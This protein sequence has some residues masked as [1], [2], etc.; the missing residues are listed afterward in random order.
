MLVSASGSQ[1]AGKTTVLSKL[2][3]KYKIIER[4]TSRSILSDWGVTLSQVNND[5]SLTVQFQ[6]EI[7]KRKLNDDTRDP[8]R[9]Y[10]TERTFADL[11]VYALVA[12]GKDNEYSDWLDDYY[13]RCMQ[14]QERYDLVFYFTAG[15]FAPPKDGVR[16]TNGH[17]SKLVDTILFNYTTQMID[18]KKLI[19]VDTANLW[20]RISIV[21]TMIV[22]KCKG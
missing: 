1:G 9:I 13:I 12:I 2:A 6:E 15:Y 19:V 21:D 10:L 22:T 7:L 4:K 5:R 17:Y 3:D 11:F 8:F 18:P 16:G 14:A 20:E